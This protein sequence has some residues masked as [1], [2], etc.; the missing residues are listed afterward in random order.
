MND[1]K[2]ILPLNIHHMIDKTQ[3]DEIFII[4]ILIKTLMVIIYSNR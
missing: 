4:E 2:I 1:A 3:N